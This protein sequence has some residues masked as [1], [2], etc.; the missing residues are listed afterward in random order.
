[1]DS[2]I[3]LALSVL[4]QDSV[5][6]NRLTLQRVNCSIGIFRDDQFAAIGNIRGLTHLRKGL[7][8][9]KC[10]DKVKHDAF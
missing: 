3:F 10:F 2:P 7:Q 6:S 1:M 5:N 4:M 9:R 8:H